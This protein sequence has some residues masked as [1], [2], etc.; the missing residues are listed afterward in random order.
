M[1]DTEAPV[2]MVYFIAPTFRWRWVSPPRLVRLWRRRHRFA[3][4]ALI[5]LF[6]RWRCG[7]MIHVAVGDDRIV[8]E[9]TPHGSRFWPGVSWVESVPGLVLIAEAGIA[10]PLDLS[11]LDGLPP[12]RAVPVIR[13]SLGFASGADDCVSTTIAVLRRA[14][15]PVPESILEP[16]ELAEWLTR[17]YPS[18][19]CD[20]ECV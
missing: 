2:A 12:P 13:K 9:V 17:R 10:R 15:C 16:A 3:R 7:A 14:G 5:R 8:A 1:I 19:A 18:H 20:T 6:L 4:A 11:R